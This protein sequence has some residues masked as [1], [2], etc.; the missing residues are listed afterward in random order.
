MVMLGSGCST[1]PASCP[2]Q[3]KVEAVRLI[4]AWIGGE[5][6]VPGF[7]EDYP[8]AEWFSHDER[9]TTVVCDFLPADANVIEGARFRRLSGDEWKATLSEEGAGGFDRGS[10]VSISLEADSGQEMVL[11]VRISKHAKAGH[12]YRFVFRKSF[13]RLKAK[14][15]LK[16]VS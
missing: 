7:D 16:G 11:Y 9:V 4:L 10:H 14:G 3:D 13:G 1:S 8:D 5:Q 12:A 15:E 6:R 2:Q